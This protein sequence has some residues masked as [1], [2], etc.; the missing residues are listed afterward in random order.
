MRSTTFTC[1]KREQY[2]LLIWK[3][4]NSKKT[5]SMALQGKYFFEELNQTIESDVIFKTV[6]EMKK[7]KVK[8]LTGLWDAI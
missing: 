2:R 6:K 1:V 7:Q 3:N 5:H 4:K 8:W